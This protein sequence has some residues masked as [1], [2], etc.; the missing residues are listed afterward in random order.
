MATPTNN[1]QNLG[2]YSPLFIKVGGN[3]CMQNVSIQL[4]L[5][6][7]AQ[8]VHTTPLGAAGMS[9]GGS[10]CDGTLVSAVPLDGVETPGGTAL[11]AACF[12]VQALEFDLV[13]ADQNCTFEGFVTEVEYQGATQSMSKATYKIWGT[14]SA[15]Q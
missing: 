10:D 1:S 6:S 12:G 5:K 8:K 9:L 14:V 11:D 13:I 3:M 7:N 4:N 2:T 15:L